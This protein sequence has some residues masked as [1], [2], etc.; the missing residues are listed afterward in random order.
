MCH[1]KHMLLTTSRDKGQIRITIRKW[2]VDSLQ[3]F[4]HPDSD[5]LKF[6]EDWV[7]FKLLEH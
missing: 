7:I 5:Q 6:Y 3:Y 4:L 1:M 2:Y